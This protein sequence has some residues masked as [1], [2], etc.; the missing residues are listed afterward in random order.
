[1]YICLP[2]RGYIPTTIFY[3]EGIEERYCYCYVHTTNLQ[4]DDKLQCCVPSIWYKRDVEGPFIR[5][6]DVS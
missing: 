6:C 5:T 3:A 2:G 1:M 4:F